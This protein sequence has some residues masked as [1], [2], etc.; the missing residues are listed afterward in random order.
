ML[1]PRFVDPGERLPFLLNLSR[2]H[3]SAKADG[4]SLRLTRG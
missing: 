3:V 2:L 1:D 4:R